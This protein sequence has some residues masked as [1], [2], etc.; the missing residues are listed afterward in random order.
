[1]KRASPCSTA[2]IGPPL[3]LETMLVAYPNDRIGAD[4]VTPLFHR[5][6]ATAAKQSFLMVAQ[7]RQ[8]KS[9]SCTA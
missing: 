5:P 3:S 1:M 4:T 7:E 9:A 8:P 2:A 6:T